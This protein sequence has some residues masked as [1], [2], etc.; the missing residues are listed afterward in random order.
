MK[1]NRIDFEARFWSGSDTYSGLRLIETFFQFNELAT[2]KEMLHNIM[3]CAAKKKCV[4][5][6]DHSAVFHF[7][8]ALRS[9]VR[10]CYVLGLKQEKSYLKIYDENN[11]PPI[12]GLL[13]DQE[14]R[15]PFLVFQKAFAEYSLKDF[16]YYISVSVY[17]SL[18]FYAHSAESK[19]LGPCIHL[20]KMLD[21]AF[22]ILERGR[23]RRDILIKK[24]QRMKKRMTI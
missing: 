4:I 2:A 9:F 13:S 24:N 5:K 11:A 3:I 7:H 22:L 15:N 1:N 19:I 8:Q 17:F 21:A 12:I 14:Y 10:A 23:K 18:G 20:T 16:E 6:E